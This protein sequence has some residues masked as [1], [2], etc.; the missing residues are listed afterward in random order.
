VAA[1]EDRQCDVFQPVP[2][3]TDV[4]GRQVRAP[5]IY[6]NWLIGAIPRQGKTNAVRVL[7]CAAAL[8]PLCGLWVHELKG[9]GDLDTLERV[10]H[11]FVSGI[12]DEAIGYAAESLRLLRGE[13]EKRAERLKAL[14]RDLCPDRRVTR[15]IAQRRSLK[16]W[17]LI[18]VF[19][20]IQNLMTHVR[21]GSQAAA[22]I[23]PAPPAVHNHIHLHGVDAA[24]VAAAIEQRRHDPAAAAAAFPQP[25]PAVTGHLD[26]D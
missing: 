17:P 12:H 16:L 4:R 14:P 2:F 8:D 24:T 6:H 19:D 21:Y 15:E 10:A 9:S 23:Q 13:V 3:G 22:E 26:E 20:E 25:Y 11:R 7:A 18:G 1:A 5:L